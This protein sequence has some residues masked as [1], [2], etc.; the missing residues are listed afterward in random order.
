[1]SEKEKV[2]EYLAEVVDR[3]FDAQ[4]ALEAN[5]IYCKTRKEVLLSGG[6]HFDYDQGRIDAVEEVL[7]FARGEIR[8]KEVASLVT[9]EKEVLKTK[10]QDNVNGMLYG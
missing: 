10:K 5:S 2:E 4:L 3:L 8:M 1:M 7:K 6:N 9:E